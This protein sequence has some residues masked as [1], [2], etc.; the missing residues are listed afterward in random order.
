MKNIAIYGAGGFGREVACLINKINI[1]TPTWN[2]I[3]FFDDGKEIGSENEYGRV[4]GC[5]DVLNSWKDKLSV[6]FAIASPRVV[7]KL[8]GQIT[9]LNIEFPNIISPDLILLDDNNVK[10]GKGNIITIGCSISCNVEIGDFN[11][12]N[13]FISIGH[14]S[15]IGNFNSFMTSVRISGEVSIGERNFF[16]VSSVI[17][18]QVKIGTD[19]VIGSNSVILRKTKDGAT[20]FGNPTKIIYY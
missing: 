1:N 15:I 13:G 11:I 5:L 16:G 9:N 6:V 8:I 4:I 19:V 2:I 7:H 3:G 10:I 17:L 18:Q 20:Y 12:F 14:D